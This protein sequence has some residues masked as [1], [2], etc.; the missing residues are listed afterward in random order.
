MKKKLIFAS[1]SLLLTAI[2]VSIL[3][4]SCSNNNS[5]K[6][7][8]LIQKLDYSLNNMISKESAIDLN[9]YLFSNFRSNS[10]ISKEEIANLI[11]LDYN[12]LIMN[13]LKNN[14]LIDQYKDNAKEIIYESYIECLNDQN[15]S[16]CNNSSIFSKHFWQV[17]GHR[18]SAGSIFAFSCLWLGMQILPAIVLFLETGDGLMLSEAFASF[19]HKL[20]DFMPKWIETVV[21]WIKKFK[22]STNCKSKFLIWKGD[23]FIYI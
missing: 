9:N 22:K 3:V 11:Q 14:N 1:T 8:E 23:K 19:D 13:E 4:T 2:L 5:T 16:R 12:S 21:N 10:S 7:K 18:L 15:L 20:P 6:E 17:L